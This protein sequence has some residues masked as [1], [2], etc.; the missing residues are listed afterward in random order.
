M[1]VGQKKVQNTCNR[2][3]GH[4]MDERDQTVDDVQKKEHDD[5]N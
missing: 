2:F 4:K 5:Y 1:D 3:L